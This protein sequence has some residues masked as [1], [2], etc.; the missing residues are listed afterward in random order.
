AKILVLLRDPVQRAYSHYQM[1][2]RKGFE[3]RSFD[4]ILEIGMAS[5]EEHPGGFDPGPHATRAQRGPH[6]YL[7][8]GLYADQLAPWMEAFGDRLM[9]LFT[10]DVKQR[11]Q[12]TYD[13]VLAFLGLPAHELEQELKLTVQ[14]YEPIPKKAEKR[15]RSFYKGPDERL[16]ALLGRPVPW[17]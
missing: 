12:E 11:P 13:Q 5:L 17:Q 14:S 15:L 7:S 3:R 2:V 4:E 1:G 16:A 6:T 8:R 10:Q 9:V